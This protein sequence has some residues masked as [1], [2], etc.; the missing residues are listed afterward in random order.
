MIVQ[1]EHG[2]HGLAW[3]ITWSEAA[4]D[5]IDAAIAAQVA[6]APARADIEATLAAGGYVVRWSTRR[7]TRSRWP[8]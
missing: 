1:A 2:P 3:L 8:T 7:R 4:A 6:A 5:A